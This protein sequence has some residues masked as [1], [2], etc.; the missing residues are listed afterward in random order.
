ML[1]YKKQFLLAE[2]NNATPRFKPPT[3]WIK[4]II[5][6]QKTTIFDIKKYF[7]K[8]WN[9]KLE[10]GLAVSVRMLNKPHSP[11]PSDYC[12]PRPLWSARCIASTG[13]RFFNQPGP[14]GFPQWPHIDGELSAD[15]RSTWHP[16]QHRPWPQG[17]S[18]SG[19][20]V[21]WITR[22]ATDPSRKKRTKLLNLKSKLWKPR[23]VLI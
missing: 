4:I 5:V 12:P 11:A 17:S 15:A 1:W 10:S 14:I 7:F 13:S 6:N 20:P 8:I 22:P 3:L 9:K 23:L 21:A 2:K 16:G 18:D 19:L